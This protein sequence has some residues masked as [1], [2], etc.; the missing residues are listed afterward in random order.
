M[1]DGAAMEALIAK[2]RERG[3]GSGVGGA[4]Q[5]SEGV[6]GAATGGRRPSSGMA[7]D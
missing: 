6:S 7:R 1:G 2:K 4:T 3:G 5:R